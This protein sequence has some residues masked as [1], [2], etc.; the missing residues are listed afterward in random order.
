MFQKYL[1]IKIRLSVLVGI[2]AERI[3]QFPVR[4]IIKS[5][6]KQNDIGIFIV[7]IT[8]M[9]YI[10]TALVLAPLFCFAQQASREKLSM[11]RNWKFHLGNAADP[12]KDFGY[13][14]ERNLAKAGEGKQAISADFN[15]SNW[16]TVNLPHDWA[17]EQDF[18]NVKNEHVLAHGYKAVGALFPETSIGWYRKSFFVAAKDSGNRFAI[19][20]DGAYRNYDVFLNG[21]FLGNN[22][23]GYTESCF[24]VTDYLNYHKKNELVVRVDATQYEGWFYEGAGIYRHVWLE[25]FNNVHIAEYGTYVS[26]VNTDSTSAVSIETS[27]INNGTARARTA[28][29]YYVTDKEGKKIT[30]TMVEGVSVNPGEPKKIKQQLNIANPIRWSLENP[31]LYK[32]V[33]LV[34]LDGKTLDSTTT[35]FGV[36]TI[37]IDKDKGVLLNGKHVKIKGTNCHQDHAGVGAALPD[38]LQYYRIRKLKE[39]GS[40]AYRTSHNPPTPELLQACDELGMLV[41]DENRLIGTSRQYTDEFEKL[42]KRDRNHPCIFLWSIGNEEGWIQ[43]TNVGKRLAQTM[44]QRQKELDPSRVCTYAADMGNERPGINEVIPVRG[45]NYRIPLVDDYHRDNPDQPI[46]GTETGS[47][48]CTRGIYVADTVKGY[49]PDHDITYPWWASS[50]EQWWKPNA[51]KDWFMGGF[52]WTGFDYRGE[53]TPY[54]WPNINSH[55]GIMDVCGFPKNN[56][57]YYQSWWS[58]KDV[59]QVSPHWNWQHEVTDTIPVKDVWVNSN[60]ATVELFLNKKSLGKKAMP[61]NGHL[62]WAVPYKPGK[63]EAVGFKNGKKITTSVETTGKPAKIILSADRNEINADGEDVCVMNITVVDE[64]G[65]EVPDA[66]NLLQFAVDGDAKIIGV[67]NGDPSSHEPDK[68]MDNKW[69]RQLFNGKCQ[70][71]IQSKDAEGMVTFTATGA[72]LQTATGTITSKKQTSKKYV[73]ETSE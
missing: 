39:M 38:A 4:N 9:K 56:Y 51:D 42:I 53:P 65:R 14:V 43:K 57:Y 11:D 10:I 28:L 22:Q 40:N 30:G 5:M 41:L 7:N 8:L 32:L 16:R 21:H 45:F 67:G 46:V 19:H 2:L 15:D 64:K 54:E 59:L 37:A 49:V 72:G 26:T 24:D 48:V 44:I 61:A 12:A 18:V 69:Q 58:D 17:V 29:T 63:L 47:T 52:V 20:F 62:Q 55:F 13:G 73:A 1:L 3:S 6:T 34:K 31:Y 50:A 66:M 70:V 36:R 25:Q 33:T 60:A 35:V 27:I 23:S 71:V 68:C